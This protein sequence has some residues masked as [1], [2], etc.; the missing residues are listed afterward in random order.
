MCKVNNQSNDTTFFIIAK[1]SCDWYIINLMV[2]VS[3]SLLHIKTRTKKKI[4]KYGEEDVRIE[5]EDRWG[6]ARLY[7]VLGF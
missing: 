7:F 1:I 5:K 4:K 2:M 3:E 6:P